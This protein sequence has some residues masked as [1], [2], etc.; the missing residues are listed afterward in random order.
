M[1]EIKMKAVQSSN[2]ESIGYDK[3]NKILQVKFIGNG[4]YQYYDVPATVYTEFC[5]AP[6]L[7]SYLQKHI[8]NKY[9]YNKIS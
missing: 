3:V 5:N 1:S 4:V 7:G 6:S 9:K 2:L 8:R